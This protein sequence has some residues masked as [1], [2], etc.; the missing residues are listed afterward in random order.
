M[1]YRMTITLTDQ[2][3]QPE[4]SFYHRVNNTALFEQDHAAAKDEQ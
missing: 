3:S 1:A 2:E 4:R